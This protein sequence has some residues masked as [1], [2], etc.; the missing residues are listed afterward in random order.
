[1]K[2][3]DTTITMANEIVKFMT[4]DREIFK[5]DKEVARVLQNTKAKGVI[6]DYGVGFYLPYTNG[7]TLEKLIEYLTY[8]EELD[9]IPINKLVGLSTK[10]KEWEEN[11]MNDYLLS[12]VELNEAA[13]DFNIERLK[14]L[15]KKPK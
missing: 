11:F 14:E 7:R 1:M 12:K 15:T 2:N 6:E 3:I 9:N 8:Q 10:I 13:H 5:V 4:R